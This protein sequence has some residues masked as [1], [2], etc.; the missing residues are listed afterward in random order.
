MGAYQLPV[1]GNMRPE[2]LITVSTRGVTHG[3]KVRPTG[4]AVI[5]PRLMQSA[6]FQ[7]VPRRKGLTILLAVSG[8]GPKAKTVRNTYLRVGRVWIRIQPT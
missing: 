7:K 5:V 2:V 8:N 1:N 4:T 3:M 6:L